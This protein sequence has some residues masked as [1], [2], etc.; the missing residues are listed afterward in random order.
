MH[1]L[2]FIFKSFF[3]ISLFII[4][5][6]LAMIPAI[7]DIFVQKKKLLKENDIV[8]MIAITQTI[9]GLIAVN[10]ALFIGHRLSGWKGG[11]IAVIAVLMPSLIIM[12]LI[13]AYLP[14]LIVNNIHFLNAF[15]CIRA[16]V[17]GIF[18]CLA[19]K[20]RSKIITSG[21]DVSIICFLI[22]GLICIKNP[23]YL[24]VISILVGCITTYKQTKKVENI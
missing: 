8:D 14:L 4:G 7:E 24:I 16:S 13:A 5:G 1:M 19:F 23:I 11:L 18:I 6:G 21:F 15:S 10:A 22:L 12:S 2:W 17:T 20:L 9:P 3:K